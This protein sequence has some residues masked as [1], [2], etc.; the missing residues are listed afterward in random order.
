MTVRLTTRS[1][2]TTRV[3]RKTGETT[4]HEGKSDA[5]LLDTVNL[6]EIWEGVSLGIVDGRHLNCTLD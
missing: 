1:Q 3:V 5:I 4:Q 2:I 6:N